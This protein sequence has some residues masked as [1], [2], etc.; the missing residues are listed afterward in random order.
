VLSIVASL[1]IGLGGGLAAFMAGRSDESESIIVLGCVGLVLAVLGFGTVAGV[2]QPIDP[3]VI[4]AEP[5]SDRHRTVGLLAAA[6]FGP[7][8]L[9]GIAIGVGLAA[10]TIRT[11][12]AAAAITIAVVALLLSLLLVARTATNLLSLL[13]AHRPRLGQLVAGLGGLV[14]YGLFQFIPALVSELDR[15]ERA[16]LAAGLRWTPPGQLGHA[17]VVA[18]GSPGRA[19]LHALAGAIWLAPLAIA[20]AVTTRR[21]AVA[22]R[23]AGGGTARTDRPFAHFVRR[24]CGSGDVGAIAWR[25]T[26]TRFRTPRTAL[27]TVTGAGVGLAAVI[28]PVVLRDDPGSGA[29]LVGGAVQLAVLFIAG[30]S[31]GNDGPAITYELLTGVSPETLV[32]AK[33]RSILIVAAPLALL[34]PVLAA[35]LTGEWRYLPAGVGVGI[36]GLL[37]GVGAAVVQSALV[38]IAVPESDNPFASGE[39]GKGIVAAGLLVIVLLGLAVAT[40]PIGLALFWA[41]E[42][43]RVWLVTVFAAAAIVAGWGVERLGRR[44]ATRRLTGRDPEFIASVTPA[45]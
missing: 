41:V 27:E 10:G 28:A 12:D 16:D 14:F 2:S 37:A 17:I 24:L 32:A 18:D 35:S 29:V 8:G 19:A 7:P 31:F 15:A 36:G 23:S 33:A 42:D 44:L 4:A 6:A 13:I 43:G 45:R 25:S 38:P 30:N 3:R 9:A 39:T 1:V 5:L 11:V 34:G 26:L 21:L 22:V 20:F 40:I